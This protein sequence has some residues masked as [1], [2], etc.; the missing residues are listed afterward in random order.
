MWATYGLIPVGLVIF[1]MGSRSL[2]MVR[3][4]QKKEKK[5]A[6]AKAKKDDGQT[7]PAKQTPDTP[8]KSET[9]SKIDDT[10]PKAE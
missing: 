4:A 10:K 8:A 2:G 3:I 1:L 7:T 9:P 6:E 5:I